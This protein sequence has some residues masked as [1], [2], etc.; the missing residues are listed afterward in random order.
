MTAPAQTYIP[1]EGEDAISKAM[2][3]KLHAT[4]LEY[5]SIQAQI[6]AADGDRETAVKSWM[7]STDLAAA[8]KLR[9]QIASATQRLRDLAE[10]NVSSVEL[11]EDDRAKLTAELDALKGRIKSGYTVLNSMIESMS[12][13]PENVKKSLESIQ[14]P[15]ASRKG[16]KAGSSGS[17]LP[18]ISATVTI[19]GGNFDQPDMPN[20]FDSFSKVA[21]VLNCEVVDLQKAFAAAAG[22]SHE[23][24]KTVTRPID[25]EFQPNENGPVYKLHTSPKTR[26]KRGSLQGNKP[27]ETVSTPEETPESTE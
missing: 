3:E 20:E 11:T 18:R 13:D 26:A 14:N 5:S 15:A 27:A 24:I 19:N 25:F 17:T 12:D 9:D 8:V 1:Y 2:L 21:S 7:E 16:V 23:N 10:K 22:V 6:A 4:T